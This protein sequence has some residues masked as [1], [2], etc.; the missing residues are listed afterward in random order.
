MAEPK[1]L[2]QAC[3]LVKR[4]GSVQALRGADFCVYPGE[5]VALM[6]DNGAGKSTLVRALCGGFVPDA[7]EILFQGRPITMRSP[8]DAQALGMETVYQ[9]LAL[10][11]DLDAAANLFLGRELLRG[12]WGRRLAWLDHGEMR[13][14]TVQA[15]AGMQVTLPSLREPI[16]SLSGGQ[17][18]SIA[19]VRAATWAQRLVFMDE[20]TAALGVAQTRAVLELIVRVRDSGRA[21]VLISHNL[22]DVMSVADRVEVLRLGRRTARFARGEFSADRI[23]AAITGALVTEPPA[24]GEAIGI[25]MAAHKDM[26]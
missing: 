4:F 7:G 22:P 1:P 10:A 14:R 3:Q 8:R 25:D 5:V 16:A 26:P 21:V 17:R 23:V 13:R 15:L 2:L 19:V 12:G 24:S 6:G 9:D 11:P 20:P 18:Q